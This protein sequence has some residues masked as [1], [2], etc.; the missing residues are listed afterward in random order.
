[1]SSPNKKISGQSQKTQRDV[2]ALTQQLDARLKHISK[3]ILPTAPYLLEVQSNYRVGQQQMN[4]WRRSCPFDAHEEQLQ[5]M[6]F[7]PHPPDGTLSRVVGGWDDGKGNFKPRE[8]KSS[9]TSS[10]LPGQSAKKKISL[11][12]YKK[13]ASGQSVT[14]T[15][16][17]EKEVKVAHKPVDSVSS[18]EVQSQPKSEKKKDGVHGVKR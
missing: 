15:P 17:P 18:M 7:Y 1:M 6:T 4:D 8:D 14:E 12:D 5:Y 16:P 2:A 13:K 9:G 11:L 10:P 3:T